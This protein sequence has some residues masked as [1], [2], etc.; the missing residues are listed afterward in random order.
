MRL[1]G[2]N[3]KI[4]ALHPGRTWI[5]LEPVGYAPQLG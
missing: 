4:I 3:G 1:V 5:E 2:G